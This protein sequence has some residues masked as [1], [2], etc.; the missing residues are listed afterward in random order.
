MLLVQV[1]WADSE[2][3]PLV[4]LSRIGAPWGLVA[5]HNIYG[6]GQQNNDSQAP[7]FLSP[8]LLAARPR[9]CPPSIGRAKDLHHT[10]HNLPR[11]LPNPSRS[12][13]HPSAFHHIRS[14]L[15]LCSSSILPT[16]GADL[17][18]TAVGLRH[19]APR[20]RRSSANATVHVSRCCSPPPR[21]CDGITLPRRMY[22]GLPRTPLKTDGKSPRVSQSVRFLRN[23]PSS[24]GWQ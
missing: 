20:G 16:C 13:S 1:N 23:M 6:P 10:P 17:Y 7:T 4:Q 8:P 12:P 3:P 22:P 19:I 11:L 5:V 9:R 14:S 2:S 18:E 15:L 24:E 21:R